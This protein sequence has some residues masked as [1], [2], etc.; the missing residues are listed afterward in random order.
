[1]LRLPSQGEQVA[2]NQRSQI[3]FSGPQGLS[4]GEENAVALNKTIAYVSTAPHKLT[5]A[6]RDSCK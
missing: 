5:L 3:E 2:P 6:E 4:S 1:M